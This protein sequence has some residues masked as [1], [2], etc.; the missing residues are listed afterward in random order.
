MNIKCSNNLKK[1]KI[2]IYND[3]S[4]N[5]PALIITK[6]NEQIRKFYLKLETNGFIKQK[7]VE[8]IWFV[9]FVGNGQY[10]V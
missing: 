3:K 1:K 5:W 10:Y 8:K 2:Y 6:I 7:R 9:K 4:L